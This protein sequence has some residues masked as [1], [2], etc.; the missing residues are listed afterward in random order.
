M[1]TTYF[2]TSE[3]TQLE[4]IKDIS[5]TTYHSNCFGFFILVVVAAFVILL[6]VIILAVCRY[7]AYSQKR[8]KQWDL[9]QEKSRKIALERMDKLEQKK[10]S[11]R[12]VSPS[13]SRDE[14]TT[15][16]ESKSSQHGSMT[17]AS[18]MSFESDCQ[19]TVF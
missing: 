4:L 10:P 7:S 11:L 15:S 17:S 3:E 18:S 14:S 16:K 9:E 12:S 2:D 6:M 13:A 5:D 19:L 8:K 1:E